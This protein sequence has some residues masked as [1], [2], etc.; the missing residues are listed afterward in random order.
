MESRFSFDQNQ[1]NPGGPQQAPSQNILLRYTLLLIYG[2]KFFPSQ[3]HESEEEN[4]T[5]SDER[6]DI[7]IHLFRNPSKS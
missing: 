2:K 1:Y 5:I 4:F 7:Q 6:P 3:F